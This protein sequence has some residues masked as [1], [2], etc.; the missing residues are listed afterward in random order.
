MGGLGLGA[1]A[2]LR[3]SIDDEKSDAQFS[4]LLRIRTSLG[5][6][7]AQCWLS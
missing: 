5:G 6:A 3:L 4:V 7:A 1:K 2:P